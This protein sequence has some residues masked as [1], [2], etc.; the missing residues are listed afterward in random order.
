[1]A[2]GGKP[3][4]YLTPSQCLLPPSNIELAKTYR[5]DMEETKEERVVTDDVSV[6]CLSSSILVRKRISFFDQ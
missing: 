3:S 1:V 5:Y 6:V 2:P 4:R